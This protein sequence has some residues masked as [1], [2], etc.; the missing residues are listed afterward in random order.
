M[1][2][3]A[4]SSNITDASFV[5]PSF[6]YDDPRLLV[7]KSVLDCFSKCASEKMAILLEQHLRH[8]TEPYCSFVCDVSKIAYI[9]ALV[10]TRHGCTFEVLRASSIGT[11]VDRHNLTKQ[12]DITSL[13]AA[14]CTTVMSTLEYDRAFV[15]EFQEDLSGKVVYENMKQS[16]EDNAMESWMDMY[17]PESDIPLPARQMYLLKQLRVVFDTAKPPVDMIGGTVDI[18][19]CVMRAVHPV[20]ISYLKNMGVR[21][22]LSV[23][24][25]VDNQLWGLMCFHSYNKAIYPRGDEIAKIETMGSH[26]CLCLSNIQK[27]QFYDKMACVA[28]V[29]DKSF[30][31]QNVLA[32]FAENADHLIRALRVDCV[33]VRLASTATQSWGELGLALADDEVEHVCQSIGD[34]LWKMGELRHPWRGLI[35]ISHGD[36]SLVLVR[37]NMK[38]EKAWGGDPTYVKLLRPDGVP[39][40]RGS[41]ERYIQAGADRDNTWDIHDRKIATY[42]SSRIEKLSSVSKQAGPLLLPQPGVVGYTTIPSHKRFDPVFVSHMSH[43]LNTP[44]HELSS[45]LQFLLEDSSLSLTAA[46]TRKHLNRGLHCVTNASSVVDSVL[47][48]VSGEEYIRMNR[49]RN[50]ESMSLQK[51][52]DGLL[53]KFEGRVRFAVTRTVNERY[54]RFQ[55][56]AVT[57][58]ETLHSIIENAVVFGAEHVHLSLSCFATHREAILRWKSETETYAHRNIRNSE[59]TSGLLRS[60]DMWY[61]FSVRDSGCGIHEDMVDNVLAYKDDTGVLKPI[62]RSHQGVGISI[63]DCM[64]KVFGMDGT[65][66][67]ASTVSKGSVVS[68]MVPARVEDGDAIRLKN[69]KKVNT[70][71]DLGTFFV[72]DDNLVTQ[73]LAAKLVQVAC[74]K[75]FGSDV[76]VETFSDGKKCVEQLERRRQTGEKVTGILMDHHMPVMSGKEAAQRIREMERREGRPK[77][78]IFGFTADST[79]FTM[80]E[81]KRS[82]MDEVLPKP[83]SVDILEDV[84]AKCLNIKVEDI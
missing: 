30:G 75:R 45:V 56:D 63:Y 7:G 66:A 14:A 31:T 37:G 12:T 57:L 33:S 41:F 34:E 84:C 55:A 83:L 53:E 74:R 38:F 77:T 20:H 67:I 60:S 17:F 70:A 79:N 61:L 59:R 9:L 35:A 48:V 29:A 54:D 5:S 21:S 64:S 46:E 15:Y 76:V 2:V 26:V 23:G 51:M 24:I 25:I 1:C 52:V 16:A 69:S 36:I 42:L 39:G 72:V 19:R 71:E 73:K 10:S 62:S 27:R 81:L 11:T 28:A 50:V 3:S 43:E 32:F 4:V 65:I 68:I 58:R 82:G 18:S 47:S 8:E 78:P 40:P 44:L 22:S 6:A 49:G 13:F 80:E